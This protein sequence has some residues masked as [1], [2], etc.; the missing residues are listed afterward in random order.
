M[1]KNKAMAI[2]I[3]LLLLVSVSAV[4]IRNPS[5]QA[6]SPPWTITSYA[7]VTA[8]PNPVGVGQTVSVYM[9]VD[10][11]LLGASASPGASN[12]I[13][14]NNYQLS[15]TDPNGKTI[16]QTWADISDPTGI[17][18]YT[19]TP[20][21]AGNY[22]VFFNYPQ[23]T[24]IWNSSTVGA[25]T[26]YTGDIFTAANT[27]LTFQ[28]QQSPVPSHIT[29]PALPSEFWTYPIYGENYNWYTVA[30]NWLSVPYI[31]GANPSYGIPGGYQPYGSAPN[32]A[33]VMWSNPIQFGGVVGGNDTN[34][35]GELYYQGGSYNTRFNNP[36]IMQGMLFFAL[37]LGETGTGGN[38]VAWDLKTGKQ[39]WSINTTATGVSLVP[40][41]GYLY[42]M[43]QPNQHGILP[44]G[45]L[46]ATTTA[47]AGLGTTWRFYD[48]M[49]GVLTPMNVTN[50]PG[51]TNIPG[52]AGE[53]LK[54]N[55]VNLGT[56]ANPNWMLSEWNSSKVFGIY[57]GTGTS[58]WYS[59][60]VPA[61]CPLSGPPNTVNTNWNGT[62]WVNSTVSAAQG[63]AAVSTPA[64][65]WNISLSLPWSLND[66]S[67]TIG[68]QASGAGPLI[69]LGS[70]ALL[71]QGTFGGHVS[72]F[73]AT[74]T[75]A[76]ANITAISLDPS[77]LGKI[78]WTQTYQP[79]PGNN[80]RTICSWDPT[81]G[82]FIFEDKETSLHYGYSLSTGQQLWGPV[83]VP[84]GT[85]EA[86]NYL[87]LDQDQAAYGN[88]YFF[89]YTGF[90]YCFD[91]KTGT[92]EWTFGNGNTADNST[93]AGEVT[94]YG[95]YPVFIT[96]IADG[97]IYL[98][99]SEHSPNSPLYQGEQFRCINASTGLQLWAISDFGNCMYGGTSPIA[100]GYLCVDNTYDQQIYSY[101]QGP[102]QL[103]VTAPGTAI[104]VGTPVTITGSVMD[105]SAGTQQTEQKA[106][107][108]NGVPAVSDGNMSA[109]M[110]YVYMQQPQPSNIIGV[111]VQLSLL[112][113]NGNYRPIG[114]ATT[115]AS[116]T[117][118]FSWTP[119]IPGTYTVYA[120]FA[121]S[122][123]YFGSNAET[124]FTATRA[125]ATLQPTLPPQAETVTMPDLAMYIAVAAVAIIIAIALV[126]LLI[127]RKH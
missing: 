90:V 107:F 101:G 55:L 8:A 109:W 77:T 85:S 76:P 40:S 74:V 36:I 13:R 80:T 93:N 110:Q 45:A 84:A 62:M 114:N 124:Y 10:T 60:N 1:Q 37:P 95:Y 14:R 75:T 82:V 125:P 96:A 63:Y 22:T 70:M 94:P 127:L 39:L 4:L 57:A 30:S 26:A 58:Y 50:V 86:W 89:G 15:I 59:G 41:F 91:D 49:T 104:P 98:V 52:P 116:G 54:L 119:D 103:T 113:A 34:V 115:D 28:V 106:D 68:A 35:A 33:H 108:P 24:Y 12:D 61:N 43:D 44:D 100:S 87:S 3:A 66:S 32:T 20:S 56:A 117:F 121:G 5:V 2:L 27:T 31:M 79:A 48:P 18:G 122:Q 99:S 42:S 78:L 111:P 126:G 64:Y 123:S 71:I 19:F 65:D 102:T 53:Y 21:V 17:Q 29:N 97:K 72:D 73:G 38:Y 81:T 88:L 23:Q 120:T 11:A 6:H 69:E 9:W 7:Y 16:T 112:D 67:W 46:V 25:N 47:Y 83:S 92:F 105:I 118:G 51:G